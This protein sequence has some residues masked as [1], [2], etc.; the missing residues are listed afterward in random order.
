M[1]L[2]RLAFAQHP[3][4]PQR[5][6]R[7]RGVFD[8]E[9]TLI[10]HVADLYTDEDRTIRFAAVAM[11]GFMGLGKEHHLVPIE[12]L[13]EEEHGSV[14]LKVDQKSVENT[15]TLGDPHAAPEGT[16]YVRVSTMRVLERRFD[17]V[18]RFFKEALIPATE[19][20]TGFCGGLMITDRSANRIVTAS[21][22]DSQARMEYTG[23]CAHLP[24]Q[25]STLVQ[26]LAALP[27]TENYQLNTIS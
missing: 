20:Q 25:I 22:W 15:P 6:L 4:P 14:Y 19:M 21:W 10:G 2:T 11:G 3:R 13:A 8:S 1:E 17:D 26:Y 7:E 27:E 18:L 5:E 24:E 16:M 12:T 23:R 9:G